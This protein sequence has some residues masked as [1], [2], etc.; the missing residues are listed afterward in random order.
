MKTKLKNLK[1]DI[2]FQKKSEHDIKDTRFTK[3]K[4]WLMHLGINHNGSSFSKEVVEDAIPTLANTP[5]LGYV[6]KAESNKDFSDHRMEIKFTDDNQKEYIYH[7]Q[8]YGV[9][10]ETHNARFEKRL[11]D[12]G[13]EREFLVVDGLLWNKLSDGIDILNRDLWKSQSMELSDEDGDYEGEYD[14]NF[15][16]HFKKFKFYGA[17]FLGDNY[18]PAM[19]NAKIELAF[20]KIK[21]NVINQ[22]KIFNQ[23]IEKEKNGGIFLDKEKKNK[24]ENLNN[25]TDVSKKQGDALDGITS[26]TDISNVEKKEEVKQKNSDIDNLKYQIEIK[27]KDKKIEKL[28]YELDEKDKEIEK[29]SKEY[30]DYKNLVELKQKKDMLDE[31]LD[32][33]ED[34]AD[35]K[36]LSDDEEKLNGFTIEELRKELDSLI[37]KKFK[38]KN[39]FSF[40]KNNG[41]VKHY[42]EQEVEDCSIM[43]SPYGSLIDDLTFDK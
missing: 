31:Y 14:E 7:G 39:K 15:I 35:Y 10:P 22:V 33:L 9:I 13:L 41:N 40:N 6:E 18:Q 4:I 17:C 42:F 32:I 28:T 11:C 5:I 43:N 37:G 38:K 34:T 19:E 2:I 16:Y 24:F 1:C 12:D 3:V 25:E 20:S 30:Q 26:T 27:E 8:S 23:F 36:V 21:D 29:I